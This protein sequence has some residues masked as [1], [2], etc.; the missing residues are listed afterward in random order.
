MASFN[1]VS[2]IENT[3][4][5]K[6]SGTYNS[7]L[8][9][10][11]KEHFTESQQQLFVTSFYC[12]L[13]YNQ[14]TDFVID[15]DN[16]WEWLGFT[17]KSSAKRVL[18][19]HFIL[20]TDYK[21]LLYRA[22][23]QAANT[24]GGHNK[25]TI[26][27]NVKTFKLLCIKAGTQKANELHEYF[28]KLEE[29]LNTIIQEESDEL[30][31]Q[32]EQKGNQILDIE[33][34]NKESY[35][36][37]LKEKEE[38]K[39][40]ILLAKYDRDISII[41]II[42]V[43]TYEN[44]EY[45]VKIGESQFGITTQFAEDKSKYEEVLILDCF[46]INHSSDFRDFIHNY[47]TI[48]SAQ[49]EGYDELFLVGRNLQYFTL[50]N[51]IYDNMQYF[52]G[53]SIEQLE[54]ETKKS[55]LET[56][57]LK[58]EIEKLK[59]MINIR[60]NTF[61]TNLADM[62]KLLLDKVTNLE[63]TIAKLNQTSAPPPA[64]TVTGFNTPLV[65]IGPR[66]QKINPETL[67]LVKVYETVS[68][69]MNEN[70]KIK[71]PSINKA[72]AE[73]TV[74]EG[75]RWRLVDRNLDATVLTEIEPTKPTRPQHLGYIAKLNQDKTEILNVYLDRKTA[76]TSNGYESHAALDAPVKQFKISNGHYYTLYESCDENLKQ[77][78]SNKHGEP[79]LYK[80]GVGQYDKDNRLVRSFICKY[81][82]IR[83]L[84]MSDKTLAKALDNGQMFEG[85]YYRQVG[86]KT[87]MV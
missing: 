72:A 66:L 12:Y 74:Y 17:Q 54:L 71:R 35:A 5:T 41:Y 49:V 75:F 70:N 27:L 79:L 52:D 61:V 29:I 65:T 18:E 15:L 68:E 4:I 81:D 46:A 1:V 13:N 23:E 42:K 6:L 50:V 3:T 83:T 20:D 58:L 26:M 57:K 44:G 39:Q 64:K 77:E 87:Q 59:L 62:V 32:L 82:C 33:N 45:L 38:E 48:K 43:K 11:I 73:N 55:Q 7:K 86:S 51:I 37:L 22:A 40:N 16:I 47:E 14:T 10:R 31:Q 56:E 36:K 9:K 69:C 78:F 60:D 30:K 19:R 8:L 76:A 85:H 84:K 34:R 80:D 63:Q 2:L 21:N 67:Q 25:E 53:N 24:H 28:I